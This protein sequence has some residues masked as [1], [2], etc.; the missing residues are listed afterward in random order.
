MPVLGIM[1]AQNVLENALPIP[2]GNGQEL[3]SSPIAWQLPMPKALPSQACVQ[4]WARAGV[5]QVTEALYVHRSGTMRPPNNAWQSCSMRQLCMSTCAGSK[6]SPWPASW[7]AGT[8]SNPLCTSWP[9]SF[10]DLHWS[11]LW[12]LKGAWSLQPCVR[13]IG[14]MHMVCCMGKV[15]STSRGILCAGR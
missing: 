2:T 9:Q 14:S 11:L 5:S 1:L 8:S 6:G 10:S 3:G 7:P 13:L 15:L 4:S 12:L